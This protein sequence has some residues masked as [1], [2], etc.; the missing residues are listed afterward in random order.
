[1]ARTDQHHDEESERL[2]RPSDI[3]GA[4]APRGDDP[5]GTTTEQAGLAAAGLSPIGGLILAALVGASCKQGGFYGSAQLY[6]AIVLG[7]ALAVVVADIGRHGQLASLRPT[8]LR[9]TSGI[10]PGLLLAGW[11]LMSADLHGSLGSGL[12][13]A[14]AVLAVPAVIACCATLSLSA[15]ELVLDVLVLLGAGLGLLSWFGVAAHRTAFAIPGQGLWRGSSTLSYPNA[16]AALLAV[17]ALL[18]VALRCQDIRRPAAEAAS[19][20]RQ[21]GVLLTAALTGLGATMSRAGVL[22]LLVGLLALLILLGQ[23]AVLSAAW[24]PVLGS[25]VS[26]AGLLPGAST[27]SSARLLP[28]LLVLLAG[29]A[30]NLLPHRG[31]RRA[32]SRIGLLALVIALVAGLAVSQ[33]RVVTLLSRARL[34]LTSEDRRAAWHAVWHQIALHPVTGSGPGLS[35]LSWQE[36]GGP[37]RVFAYAHDEYLQLLAELGLLGMIALGCCLL[38]LV[39][40]LAR[41]RPAA[42]ADRAVWAGACAGVL[43]VASSCLFDFTAHFPAITLTAAAL[44]GC[45]GAGLPLRQNA[46]ISNE[47]KEETK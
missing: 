16:A 45:A 28:A 1:M 44:V 39:R 30:L 13:L 31:L 2:I 34:N 8:R 29:L 25:L 15:V 22:A 33:H 7:L 17:L 9:L 6:L 10:G 19:R 42:V 5:A 14:A 11:A 20:L 24:L 37:L 47:R 3:G 32:G 18:G 27:G 36:P 35:T 12:R 41:R 21:H 4:A 38:A 46:R 26:L 43:A 40:L 23:R